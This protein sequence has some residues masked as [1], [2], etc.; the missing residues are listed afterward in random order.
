M[1]VMN[2]PIVVGKVNSFYRKLR[3]NGYQIGN[4]PR[5]L[6]FVHHNICNFRCDFCYE[7]NEVKYNKEHLSTEE[8]KKLADEADELGIWEIVFQGGELLVNVDSF[9]EVINTFGPERFHM[10]LI[11]NG[12]FMTPEVAERLAAAGLDSVGVSISSLNEAEHDQSR[13]VKGSHKKAL[14]ALKNVKAAG[15]DSWAQPI[16][17]HHN[18]HSPE[19]YEFLDYL[20]ENDYGVYFILAMPYGVWKDN[21]MDAEDMRIFSE[22]RKKYK[23]T[24]FDTW[25]FYDPN[26]ERLSGCWSVNRLF[27]TPLGDVQPCPFIDISIGNVKKQSLKEIV[28]YGFS[29]KYFGETSPVC[30]AAQNRKFREKYLGRSASMFDLVSGGGLFQKEDYI[31]SGQED[32]GLSGQPEG[33]RKIQT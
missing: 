7:Q 25:D 20:Q 21:Y 27:V 5:S 1:G 2:K 6:T 15:M 23:N 9:I 19:L 29:I 32:A 16:F 11:T 24:T 28:D 3:K 22:L 17:G 30:L 13:H 12:W 8:I 26:R 4:I 18:S 10:V 31:V 14:E 33:A